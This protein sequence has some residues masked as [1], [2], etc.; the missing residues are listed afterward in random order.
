MTKIDYKKLRS[1]LVKRTNRYADGVR[2]LYD[3]A[4]ADISKV[5]AAVDYN[6]EAPFSFEDYGKFDKVD[7]IMTRLERQ[8]QQSLERLMRDVM[9]L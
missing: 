1:E 6:P 4:L 7:E 2:A 5:F 3:H 9:S 8:I